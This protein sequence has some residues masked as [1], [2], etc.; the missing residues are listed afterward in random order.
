M[1]SWNV[2]TL[3]KI[4]LIGIERH[5]GAPK[6]SPVY[7]VFG[8]KNKNGKLDA[9]DVKYEIYDR[10]A[11]N[12]TFKGICE[13]GCRKPV[14]RIVVYKCTVSK[15]DIRKHSRRF[16][17]LLRTARKQRSWMLKM[18]AIKKGLCYAYWRGAVL[19]QPKTLSFS[20]HFTISTKLLARRFKSVSMPRRGRIDP[21]LCR[22][23]EATIT[24]PRPDVERRNLKIKVSAGGLAYPT[25]LTILFGAY[26]FRA[27][28][29]QLKGWAVASYV[30]K[31]TA[32]IHLG[33]RR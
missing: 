15:G 24:F 13:A 30:F 7:I 8:D 1:T 16:S 18:P 23:V 26:S 33:I 28:A 9:N 3:P 22:A 21:R 25:W 14:P 5:S 12:R 4:T 20:R 11:G 2:A 6:D 32:Y 29:P 10:V 17:Q 19:P 27:T 31:G